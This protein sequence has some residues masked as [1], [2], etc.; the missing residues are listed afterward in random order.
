MS[1]TAGPATDSGWGFE[2]AWEVGGGASSIGA[3]HP[4]RRPR[5]RN[6][7]PERHPPI[8]SILGPDAAAVRLRNSPADSQSE[9]HAAGGHPRP[10]IE[11]VKDPL[12][13]PGGQSGTAVSHLDG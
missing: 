8:G 12:L 5:Q 10:A 1:T 4:R 7:E 3:L 6:R 13:L 11:L 9:A 2:E